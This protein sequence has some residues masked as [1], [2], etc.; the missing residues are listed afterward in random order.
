M[1][2][3]RRCLRFGFLPVL[4]FCIVQ[5]QPAA[6]VSIQQ[7][8]AGELEVWLVEDHS[9]PII[10]V[11]LAF[12]G[13]TASDPP[14]REGLTMMAAALLDEGA[15]DLDSAAFQ[16]QLEDRGIDLR[17]SSDRDA[18]RGSMRT[19]TEHA[20]I[21]FQLLGLALSAP[22]FDPEPVGRVREQLQ[23]QLRRDSE[24]PAVVAGRILYATLFPNHGYGRPGEGTAASLTGIEIDHLRRL[25]RERLVR[26]TLRIGVVGDITPA[27]L[28][29]MIETTFAPLPAAGER[30]AVSDVQPAH[31]TH[32]VVVEMPARQ[33]AV[34]FAQPGL[35]RDHPD[36]YALSVVNQ[37]FGGSGLNSRLFD[38]VRE[39]R[40][41]V[42]GVGTYLVTLD[43]GALIV[44]QAATANERVAE[45]VQVVRQEWQRLSEKG[46]MAD[47]VADAK[48]YLT[49]SFPLRLTSSARI[50]A[51]LVSIQRDRLGI[52]YL[53]RRNQLIESVSV[54]EANRIA[55]T[56]FTPEAL[57]V[58]VAGRPVGLNSQ[59]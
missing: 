16:R 1:T 17:F 30:G 50:A 7:V 11:E 6:A 2:C 39:K 5:V 42:Y 38:E 56:V 58:V 20:R 43:H 40:G 25:A 37:A 35:A 18:I 10:A 27:E 4:L 44:G 52:D 12:D 3:F 24:D 29:E 21:A 32:T 57:T 26:G 54:E 55:R 36:Y 31:A 28:K 15:G 14:G 23:A 9:N 51:M 53:D 22:R 13:G 45:T 34:A 49:G 46:L 59:H 48:S 19:L 47:E 8:T 41:L 33:S